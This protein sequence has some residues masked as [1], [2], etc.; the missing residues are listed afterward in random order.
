MARRRSRGRLIYIS[1]F[2]VTK[3]RRIHALN[4][5]RNPILGGSL[6]H[7]NPSDHYNI[8]ESG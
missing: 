5:M 2:Q 8:G 7:G 3:H 6:Y 1:S 4:F